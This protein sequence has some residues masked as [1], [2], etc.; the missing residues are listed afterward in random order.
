MGYGT[1]GGAAGTTAAPIFRNKKGIDIDMGGMLLV[2]H[3]QDQLLQPTES[4]AFAGSTT[5]AAYAG[6]TSARSTSEPTT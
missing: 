2:L 5:R 1:S 4:T 3:R 6:A